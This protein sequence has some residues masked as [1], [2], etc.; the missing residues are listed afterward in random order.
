MPA[1][2][3][4][5]GKGI[6]T[7][8]MS[9]RDDPTYKPNTYKPSN[10]EDSEIS[11]SESA[12][13]AEA[14]VVNVPRPKRKSDLSQKLSE[15]KKARMDLLHQHKELSDQY[16]E[17]KSS[18][19]AMILAVTAL[20]TA[21]EEKFTCPIAQGIPTECCVDR[22]ATQTTYQLHDLVAWVTQERSNPMT[23]RYTTPDD[24][25]ALP[26]CDIILRHIATLSAMVPG[27]YPAWER[28]QRLA[29]FKSLSEKFEK[30]ELPSD[31]LQRLSTL[32]TEFD[33]SVA[34][35]VQVYIQTMPL[36]EALLQLDSLED[37]Q[38]LTLAEHWK[39]VGKLEK[40]DAIVWSLAPT[41]PKAFRL[42]MT[43]HEVDYD[44]KRD[45]LVAY[46]GPPTKYV[47]WCKMRHFAKRAAE[48]RTN[49]TAKKRNTD[50]AIE[51]G[52]K[53]STADRDLTD[54]EITEATTLLRT[55]KGEPEVT[56]VSDDDGAAAAANGSPSYSPS[57]PSYA[58]ASPPAWHFSE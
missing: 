33:E 50:R 17:L 31:D 32:A 19:H 12:A 51:W 47:C 13:A 21:A 57:S 1:R 42:I 22:F 53:M 20:I 39:T 24:V 15:E 52:S 23:R 34:R 8:T 56:E 29:I 44:E 54:D 30:D 46:V 5:P 48:L 37:G 6:R 58:P 27:E 28:L 18:Q 9:D 11:P 7:T 25:V 55:L 49:P 35:R 14:L 16:E 43:D 36:I 2:R 45:L 4:F 41:N 26:N 40:Y 10:T 3:R 38:K